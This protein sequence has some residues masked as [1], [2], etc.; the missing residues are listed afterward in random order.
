MRPDKFTFDSFAGDNLSMEVCAAL[1]VVANLYP[2]ACDRLLKSVRR[3]MPL[4]MRNEI[5]RTPGIRY[6]IQHGRWPQ[7]Q[8]E[9]PSNGHGESVAEEV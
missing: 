7:Q 1:Y 4:D 5:R 2:H 3:D 9:E 8:K 6:Y